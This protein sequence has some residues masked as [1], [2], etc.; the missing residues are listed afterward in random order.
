MSVDFHLST[1]AAKTTCERKTSLCYQ[2][3]LRSPLLLQWHKQICIFS[4][5][6]QAY[7]ERFHLRAHFIVGSL[8]C[9]ALGRLV[10]AGTGERTNTSS[11]AGPLKGNSGQRYGV[12]SERV[13]SN[14]ISHAASPIRKPGR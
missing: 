3:V 14:R 9:R 4:E 10:F 1:A 7:E 6:Q 8:G 12:L 5:S 2:D 11:K 13:K